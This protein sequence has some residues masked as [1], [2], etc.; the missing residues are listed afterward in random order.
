MAVYLQNGLVE[1][2]LARVRRAR[3]LVGSQSPLDVL[4]LRFEG[5]MLQLCGQPVQAL[6]LLQQA[7]TEG[8][9]SGQKTKVAHALLGLTHVHAQSGRLVELERA[10]QRLPQ[11]APAHVVAVGW[12]NYWLGVVYYERNQL[13]QARDY[14]GRVID[15]RHRVASGTLRDSYFYIALLDHLDGHMA[16]ANAHLEAVADTL[17]QLQNYVDLQMLASFRARL[18]ILGGDLAAAEQWLGQA[19]VQPERSVMSHLEIG[20]LTLARLLLARQTPEAAQQAL[21]HLTALAQ[22]AETLYSERRLIE[23]LAIQALAFDCLGRPDDASAALQRALA[24]AEPSGYVRTF[25]DLGP[26]MARLLREI[27]RQ[28]GAADYVGHLL[29][30]FAT[31]PS[32]REAAGA[33]DAR[34]RRAQAQLI[35]PLTERELEV[36]DLLAQRLSYQEMAQT[37]VVSPSTIKTHINHIYQKLHV[38]DRREA[39][40]VAQRLGL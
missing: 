35:E 16:A 5:R 29:Q 38:G 39:I 14:F 19:D 22:L 37:L 25:I 18:A 31:T 6:Q 10:A 15:Q 20:Q 17:S 1:Q 33:V 28:G 9:Q 40:E 21:E 27:A 34:R 7:L 4:A 3:A 24:L 13:A 11:L 2:A 8:M 12:A 26:D 30:T 32:P 36:L 23:I